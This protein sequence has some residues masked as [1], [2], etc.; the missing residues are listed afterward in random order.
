MATA[1]GW[2]V[3]GT[4]VAL[5]SLGLLL[6]AIGAGMHIAVALGLVSLLGVW[7]LRADIG[8]ATNL[9]AQA[10]SDAI[11][12]HIFGVVPLFVLTGLLVARAG[13]GEDA[14]EVAHQLLRRVRAGLGV[15]TVAANA[16]FA[17]VTGISIAS[18]AVFARVAV[19]PMRRFGYQPRFAV[20]VVAGSSVLG[21][22]IPPSLLMVLY[23]FLTNQSVGDLFTAG[24]LPGLLLAVAF[25]LT[26]VGLATWR[27]AWVHAAAAEPLPV[28][29]HLSAVQMA[30]KLLPTL[31]MIA[32]V[33][34]GLYGGWFTATEAGAVSAVLA[35]SIALAR[36][37]LNARAFWAVLTESGHITVAVSL[38]IIC[39]NTYSRMLA[40]SGLPQAL[41]AQFSA[42]GLGPEAFLF[43][44][45]AVIILLGM[46]I[47][48]SSILLIVL[49][50]VLPLAEQFGFNLVWFGIVTI[51]AVE[52]GL[53]TPPFGL[54]VFVVHGALN[55]PRVNLADVFIGT[56]PFTLTM[57][58]V[59]GAVV[60]FPWLSL[61]LL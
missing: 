5:V 48:A 26:V 18:A 9:L 60:A 39:A 30:A 31:G 24:I 14:F 16:V 45:I 1:A 58:G 20:G 10:A 22:L 59:L 57:L 25:A 36:R 44:H 52:I 40:M 49:P 34:G 15:A 3:S 38:L 56:W 54:S 23:G 43:A 46:V 7:V 13:L 32:A 42:W 50:L 27:P 29:P 51:I 19:P 11:A 35:L 4:A 6:L 55:D 41:V 33:L 17:A 37:R 47:D 21:M 53:L 28:V 12:S 2:R 8:V 61:A